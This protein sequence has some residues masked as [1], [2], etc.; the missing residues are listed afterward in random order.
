MHRII[1]VFIIALGL[2]APARAQTPSDVKDGTVAVV[3]ENP[4]IRLVTKEGAPPSTSVSFWRVL[5]SPAGAGH[6]CFLTS[7]ITGDGPTPD[8]VR[9]AFADNGKLA[10]YVAVQLMT[11]LDGALRAQWRHGNGVEGDHP[12]GRHHGRTGLAGFLRAVRHREPGGRASQPIHDPV[13]VHPRP[14]GGCHHQRDASGWHPHAPDARHASEQQRL[15]RVC[16]DL[17]EVAVYNPHRNCD[18]PPG[19]RP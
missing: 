9:V 19:S 17:A 15:P 14:G 13:D 3:G 1:V 6:V 12:L 5:Q 11:A 18:L 8:D 7:D 10:E 4:G 16:G 2:G